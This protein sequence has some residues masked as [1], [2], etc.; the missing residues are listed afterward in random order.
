MIELFAINKE[1]GILFTKYFDNNEDKFHKHSCTRK[2]N[3]VKNNLNAIGHAIGK[4]NTLLQVQVEGLDDDDNKIFTIK[5][6]KFDFKNW[7]CVVGNYENKLGYKATECWPIQLLLNENGNCKFSFTQLTLD[8]N[9]KIIAN[10][11]Y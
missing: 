10:E 9:D 2:V 6:P 11:S 5:Q 3:L 1:C 4:T 8:Y 7:K